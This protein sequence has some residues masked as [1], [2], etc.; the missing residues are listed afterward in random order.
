MK[1]ETHRAN[2][3]RG[4]I[5]CPYCSVRLKPGRQIQQHLVTIHN[6]TTRQAHMVSNPNDNQ[7]K[8]HHRLPR[9]PRKEPPPPEFYPIDDGDMPNEQGDEG[10]GDG[11]FTTGEGK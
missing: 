6:L 7:A 10:A 3:P 9:A 2:F 8:K 1:C 5:E 4:M 11:G